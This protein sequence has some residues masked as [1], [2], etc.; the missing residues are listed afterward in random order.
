MIAYSLVRED[1]FSFDLS[2][3]KSLIILE[4]NL[5]AKFQKLEKSF[6]DGSLVPGEKQLM[7]KIINIQYEADDTDELFTQTWNNF[8]SWARQAIYLQDNTNNRRIPIVFN[9]S[10]VSYAPGSYQKV[11]TNT[12]EFIA[13]TPYWESLTETSYSGTITSNS[14]TIN[15]Q[16]FVETPPIITLDTTLL[17]TRFMVYVNE[18]KL[19]IDI[20]D[21][22]FG[23]SVLLQRYVIDCGAGTSELGGASFGFIDRKGQ[24]VKGTGF[25]K[26]PAGVSNIIIEANE[27]VQ[28]TFA[29]RER[30][31]I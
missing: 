8:L 28:Y 17:N 22:S 23:S 1:G 10:T 13:L 20:N 27:S 3:I 12:V 18:T 29:F 21:I 6:N 11:A 30:F 5:T 4:D 14:F 2:F 24:I 15:N 26:V 25:F 9:G 16:G 19:G 7:D 31:Y